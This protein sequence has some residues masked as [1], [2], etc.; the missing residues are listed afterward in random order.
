MSRTQR[1]VDR[2]PSFYKVWDSRSRI[3]KVVSAIAKRLDE[4][5]SDLVAILRSHWVDTAFGGDLDSLGAILNVRRKMDEPDSR[6]RNRLY[7]A[8]AEFKGGGTMSAVLTSVKMALGVPEGAPI[9]LVEN[10]PIEV[11]KTLEVR[12]GDTWVMSSNSV[13]DA[14]PSLVISIETKD[15]EITNPTV[16]N[17]D[18][19]EKIKFNGIIKSGEELR[20][21]DGKI[22]LNGVDVTD[23]LSTTK[24]PS[25]LRKVSKWSYAELVEEVIGRFDVAT[26]D[27]SVFAIGIPTV[28]LVFRWTAYQPAT[29]EVQIPADV[30]L[31]RGDLSI[32]QE[33]VDSI[34]AAGVKAMVKVI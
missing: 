12:T 34:K 21:E 13:L 32:L 18:T 14:V 25:L 16:A 30:L 17:L 10:P 4:A 7:R 2:F 1:I 5:D 11:S 27:K 20:I 22:T 24:V 6:Y 3:F 33:A 26:F 15:A 29:F 23:R 31:G 9:R 8:I 28:K 19:D